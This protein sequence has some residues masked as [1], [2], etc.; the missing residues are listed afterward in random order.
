M[1]LLTSISSCVYVKH[2]L[3]IHSL[4]C[5]LVWRTQSFASVRAFFMMV[6]PQSM[7]WNTGTSTGEP[8][9][10]RG[11]HGDCTWW[12]V[13]QA[14]FTAL[15][16]HLLQICQSSGVLQVFALRKLDEALPG[17]ATISPLHEVITAQSFCRED[18]EG[19]PPVSPLQLLAVLPFPHALGRSPCESICGSLS[20]CA[21]SRPPRTQLVSSPLLDVSFLPACLI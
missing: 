8:E 9:Q 1:D 17:I 3:L 4:Y 7:W 10:S 14:G 13:V 16:R 6:C 18:K 19:C 20:C 5:L 11:D 12:Q 2:H 21:E 15:Q